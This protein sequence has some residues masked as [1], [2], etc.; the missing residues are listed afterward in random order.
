MLS[1]NDSITPE[2]GYSAMVIFL[3]RYYDRGGG[4]DSLAD[5]MSSI[6]SFLWGDG[7][8]NDPAMWTDWLDAIELAK[9]SEEE[10]NLDQ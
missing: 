2:I 8:P 4:A 3:E 6:S 10:Q 9:K 5:V 1:T 7:T